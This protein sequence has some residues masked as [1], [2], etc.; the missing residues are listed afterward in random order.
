MVQH[1]GVRHSAAVHVWQRRTKHPDRAWTGHP[2][3]RP[4][5]PLP[6]R[7]PR[8]HRLRSA[9]VQCP[10]PR[11]LRYA[12][13]LRRRPHHLR[14]Y[15]LRQSAA[16]DSIRASLQL[17]IFSLMTVN[18]REILASA[19]LSGAATGQTPDRGRRP[20][21]GVPQGPRGLSVNLHRAIRDWIRM[22]IFT[23][24]MVPIFIAFRSPA[25][26][27]AEQLHRSPRPQVVQ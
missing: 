16:A 22:G 12:A 26:W 4:G 18:R 25:R 11:Q 3:Y 21:K 24:A 8:R 1:S 19:L 23:L 7:R 20:G 27:D 14:P 10:E 9:G 13:E 15:L 2:G 5:A 17:L 6:D